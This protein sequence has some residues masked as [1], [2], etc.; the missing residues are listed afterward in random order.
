MTAET[1]D[2]NAKALK[3]LEG[4]PRMP[5]GKRDQIIAELIRCGAEGAAKTPLV[6]SALVAYAEVLLLEMTR[7][8]WVC[9]AREIAA[10]AGIPFKKP[11]EDGRTLL[12]TCAQAVAEKVTN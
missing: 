3:E 8:N 6:G 4:V 2:L 1:D 10:S 12:T 5:P 9:F 7:G 11:L